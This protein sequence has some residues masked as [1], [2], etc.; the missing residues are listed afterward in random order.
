M[1]NVKSGVPQGSILGPVLFL[2]FI[3]DMSLFING[4]YPEG[5]AD[6]STVHAANKDTIVVENKLQ[7]GGVGFRTWCRNNKMFIHFSKTSVTTIGT[8]Y[9][10]SR[11]DPI[12]IIIDNERIQN[13]EFKKLLGVI[14]DRI[15]SWDKQI[16][17]M[18]KYNYK[19]HTFAA[20]VKV[21]RTVKTQTIL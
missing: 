19:T 16:F 5:Y 21:S 13:V 9:H 1:Q 20:T 12:G 17:R 3:N 7:N 6:D 2:I 18:F 14:I 10:T 11:T 8:R 15:L 4:I